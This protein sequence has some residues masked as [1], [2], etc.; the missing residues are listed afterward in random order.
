MFRKV[1][2][3]LS[4]IMISASSGFSASFTLLI[5]Y[6]FKPLLREIVT[7]INQIQKE[8]DSKQFGK[9]DEYSDDTLEEM[10]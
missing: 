7:E 4:W 8:I 5:L 10:K 6:Y 3:W 1:L 9:F 2:F